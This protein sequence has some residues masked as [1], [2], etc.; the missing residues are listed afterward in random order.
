MLTMWPVWIDTICIN[1]NRL[2]RQ[3]NWHNILWCARWCGQRESTHH[4]MIS[5]YHVDSQNNA[6]MWRYMLTTWAIYAGDALITWAI[7]CNPLWPRGQH[8]PIQ[9][10]VKHSNNV[11]SRTNMWRHTLTT[12]AIYGILL[13]PRGQHESTQ[14]MVGHADHVNGMNWY[15]ISRDSLTM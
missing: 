3:Y 9:Y 15:T 10:V 1:T 6:I 7:Y 12:W 8:I 5:P 13:W 4:I 2:C 11:D 14:Y